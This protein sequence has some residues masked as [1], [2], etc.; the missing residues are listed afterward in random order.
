MSLLDRIIAN[1]S[2]RR[3]AVSETMLR[4]KSFYFPTFYDE[5]LNGELDLLFDSMIE[6]LAG[7]P[8]LRWKP[9]DATGR[10]V[11][12]EPFRGGRILAISGAA[13]VG[14]SRTVQHVLRD[15]PELSGYASANDPKDLIAVVA[16][17][18]FTL[19]SLGNLILRATGYPVTAEVKESSVWP[20]T[21]RRLRELDT[22]ILYIDEAQ[23]GDQ[24]PDPE[25]A[26]K[27]LDTLKLT[28]QD[29]AHPIWLILSGT[30]PLA[31]FLQK[32]ASVRRRVRHVT[33]ERLDYST[34]ADLVKTLIKRTVDICP[35]LSSDLAVED[36]TVGRL[37]HAAN[38]QFGVIVEYI[39]D[40]IGDCLRAGESN[41]TIHHFAEVYAARTG[42]STSD[43][44]AFLAH[45]WES[46]DVTHSL[47]DDAVD[48]TR[49]QAFSRKRRVRRGE[50]K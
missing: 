20:V 30:P 50:P 13:G 3:K 10:E 29:E 25:I 28:M 41:L 12:S 9:T 36:E 32:D 37:M 23:H 14:K 22:R 34:H 47:Y 35:G 2:P 43:R 27:V 1:Q 26:Q 33:F 48:E 15:R 42:A 7:R 49:P 44:N 46:I 21:R 16:S 18:P 5:M 6:E 19:G 11:T 24:V 39:Q 45:D 4:L 17:A 40:A 31:R 38:G 8:A